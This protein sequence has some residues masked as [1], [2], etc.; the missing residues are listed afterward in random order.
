MYIV[1]YFHQSLLFRLSTD[2]KKELSRRD[3]KHGV[4][5]E[6]TCRLQLPL[7]RTEENQVCV[8]HLQG[9]AGESFVYFFFF[10]LHCNG[11]ENR[12]EKFQA[13]CRWRGEEPAQSPY[14][15][16]DSQRKNY[17]VISFNSMLLNCYCCLHAFLFF[18]ASFPPPLP[19][20]THTPPTLLAIFFVLCQTSLCKQEFITNR[21]SSCQVIY[22]AQ[23]PI[24]SRL[25]LTFFLGEML[26]DYL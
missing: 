18:L 3:V 26:S 14:R 10:F 11:P 21:L 15:M 7:Q 23:S 6:R 24:L 9:V 17:R 19:P 8:V 1:K 20:T 5:K 22:P 16:D 4:A 13:I 2:N 12:M 25:E